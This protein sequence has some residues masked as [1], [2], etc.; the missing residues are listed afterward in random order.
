VGA[1]GVSGAM[2]AQ[3]EAIAQAGCAALGALPPP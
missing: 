1:I 2:P 3:D